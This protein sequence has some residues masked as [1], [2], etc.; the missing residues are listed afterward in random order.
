MIT[1]LLA[2]VVSFLASGVVPVSLQG[3]DRALTETLPEGRVLEAVTEKRE[4]APRLVQRT[5][6]PAINAASYVVLDVGTGTILSSENPSAIRS[7]AS[8]TKLLTA[9]TV[10][11][12]AQSSDVV[13]VSPRAVKARASGSD[14]KLLARERLSVR[15]LLAGLLIASANDAA[16]ALAEHV[17]GTESAFAMEMNAVARSLGLSRTHVVNATGLDNAEHFSTAY[18]MA[19]LLS[20]AWQDPLLGVFLRAEAL[21]VRSVDGKI[22]HHLQTTNRLLGERTD[23]LAG[24]TGF[25]DAAGQ[26]LAVIAEHDAGYPVVAVLLGSNDRF[27]DME[28]LL[29][30]TFWAYAWKDETE[31][32]RP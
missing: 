9:L 31:I 2:L 6:G 27:K 26:S 18:D 29:N 14:M 10:T 15:D 12:R 7:V 4:G 5:A 32:V 23:I 13:T 3:P 20:R 8:L 11:Q 30:W 25:T 28:N 22:L 17:R 21:D 24:K 19:L 16:V 1:T